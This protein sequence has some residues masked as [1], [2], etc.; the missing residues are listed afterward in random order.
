MFNLHDEALTMLFFLFPFQ[1]ET[2]GLS[3]QQQLYVTLPYVIC[4]NTIII[5]FAS[6][7]QSSSREMK[8]HYINWFLR[9]CTCVCVW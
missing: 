6:R 3:L 4:R 9:V 7:A 2:K 8:I 5:R 1:L